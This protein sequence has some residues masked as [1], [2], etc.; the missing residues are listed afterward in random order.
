[1][2]VNA[3]IIIGWEPPSTRFRPFSISLPPPLFPI[4]GY[5]LIFHHIK[6]LSQLADLKSVFLMGSYN[7]KKFRPFLDFACSHFNFRIVYIQEQI[8]Q[9]STGALF[10]YKD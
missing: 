10:Y 8:S 1:M 9:N 3:V 7:E 6:A 5:P 4:G 2:S